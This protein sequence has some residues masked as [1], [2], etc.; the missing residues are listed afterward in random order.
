MTTRY[1]VFFS[2]NS[3]NEREVER[4]AVRLRDEQ[5]LRVFFDE[6]EL[7]PGDSVIP[8]L[9]QAI[10]QSQTVAVFL[11]S[12]GMGPWQE[13]ERQVALAYAV[14]SKR[15]VIPVLLVGARE[16]GIPGFLGTK[17]WVDLAEGEGFERLVAGIAGRAPGQLGGGGGGSQQPDALVR[18]RREIIDFSVERGRHRQFFGREDVLGEMDAWVRE[19]DGGWLIITGSPGLGKSALMDQWLRRREAVGSLTAFHFIRR[20][21]LDW[22]EPQ[23]V[24]RSLAAQI[25]VMFPEQ[26]DPDVDPAYR[27]EQLLGRVGSVLA[28]R[29]ERLVLLVDGLDEAMT[30]GKDNPIPSIVPHE[31]PPRV[32]VVTASRPRYPHL[33][34][35]HRRTGATRWTDLD[36]YVES[37]EQAVREHWQRLGTTME[38]PL[39]EDLVHAAIG[40]AKGNLLHAVKLFE[41]WNKPN[42]KRSLGDVP[43]G[44]GGMLEELWERTG[45][46]PKDAKERVRNGLSLICAARESLPLR[47][48]DELLGWDEG[49]AEDE[50][51]PLV[52]E[53]LLEEPWNEEPAYRP[54]HEGLRELVERKRPR[55]AREHHAVLSE[56]AAW[57]IESDAFRRSYALRHRIEHRVESG[58]VDAAAKACMDVGYLT[59]KACAEGVVAVERDLRLA[60]EAR[61]DDETR[62]RLMTLGQLVAASAHWANEVP[63]ALP[64]LLHDRALTNAPELLEDL[65]DPTRPSV[66]HPR[67]RHPLQVCG[68]PRILLGHTVGVIAVAVLPDGHLVSGS[69]D[70]TLRV[71]DVATGRTLAILQGHTNSVNALAVSPDGRVISGSSDRTLRVWDVATGRTLAILQGHTSSVN[72]VAVLPDSHLV[73]GS[74]DKTLR[75]WDIA[76][77]RPLT[78]LHGHSDLVSALA[79]LPDGR[80]VSGSYDNT[81]RVWDVATER[82]LTILHGHL[83]PVSALAVL[84]DGRLVSGSHDKT[85]RVWDVATGRTLATLKGH[86]DWVSALAVLPDGC[87]VSGSHDKTLHVWDVQS[88]RTLATL[89]GHSHSVRALA[90]LP[91]S[92]LVSGSHDKTLRVWDVATGRTL[93][94]LHGHSHSVRALAVLSNGRLVS[95][96]HDKTL[97][98]WDVVTGRTLATLHGHSDWVSAVAVLPDG[99]FISGSYDNTLGVWDMQQ[100]RAFATFEGHLGPV[101]ALAMLPDG[102]L[103]SGSCDNTLRV[104]NMQQGRALATLEGHSG[105]VIAVVVLPDGRLV[106][107]SDDKTL[108]VWD[109][110]SGRTLATLHGHSGPVSSLAV[111]PDGGLVSGSDD[112]TIRVWDVQSGRTLATLH[113]HSDWVSAVAML[114]DGRLVSGSRDKTLR[115]WDVRLGRIL[116]TVY[117]DVAFQSIACVDQHLIVA[118]DAVGNVWF[119]DLPDFD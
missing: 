6:W 44:F 52:R 71:W 117:G 102:R 109:V 80:L 8:A 97:R 11:G 65:L 82:T 40:G 4:I 63:E 113:G 107:G 47:M 67:L 37:N 88:E 41:L 43:Q 79:V 19:R 50:L 13:E 77:G 34:W 104:W 32:F 3:A 114:P 93:A 53:M 73:S 46:L 66:E 61:K 95:G 26:R 21:H 105:W 70:N 20:G 49:E 76:T 87:L 118:G 115:V 119:I 55:A 12:N 110:Q 51:L 9:E 18:V 23:V 100:G 62:G 25:E 69:F 83:G 78:T 60:A 86:S 99:R 17:A 111:L 15:R 48:V 58:Q 92:R 30:L 42:A 72:A 64:A 22:A 103:I 84:P 27:L 90:V 54:F 57:P 14:K 36:E 39:G 74:N 5:G 81:L 116:A 75:V 2:Y 45:A 108:R 101:S 112:K 10:D 7:V 28:E 31:L 68:M 16:Q 106:S 35:F 98:V 1:D 56:Y 29:G 94:T 96:S 33:N 59:A 85:L 91:Y 38:P 24:Q 89:H